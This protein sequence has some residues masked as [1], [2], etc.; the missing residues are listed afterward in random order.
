[1]TPVV[2]GIYGLPVYNLGFPASTGAVTIPGVIINPAGIHSTFYNYFFS[3]DDSLLVLI[4]PGGPGSLHPRSAN[5]YDMISGNSI[6]ATQFYSGAITGI[7]LH[8]G[9]VTV[10]Y[11][12]AAGTAWQFDWVVP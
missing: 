9:R 8:A 2:N 7:T 11:T 4:G 3:P 10:R 6:G 5:L 1:M 12:D